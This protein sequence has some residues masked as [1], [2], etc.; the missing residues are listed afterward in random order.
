[1]SSAVQTFASAKA[2]GLILERLKAI[3]FA[4]GRLAL[5]ERMNAARAEIE[6][7]RERLWLKGDYNEFD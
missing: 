1:M 7:G 5:T 2:N 4:A 6:R 3:L